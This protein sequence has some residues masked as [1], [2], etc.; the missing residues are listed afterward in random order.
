[1][2]RSQ[3]VPGLYREFKASPGK[4]VRLCLKITISGW[5]KGSAV[6]RALAALAEHLHTHVAHT[7]TD[8]DIF[9]FRK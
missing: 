9:I 8:K 4:S 6:V 2:A 7:Y 1:M 5:R 3:P